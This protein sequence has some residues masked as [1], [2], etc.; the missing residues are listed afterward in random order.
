MKTFLRKSKIFAIVFVIANLFFSSAIFGQAIATNDIGFSTVSNSLDYSINALSICI[1]GK[2]TSYV[3]VGN[4]SSATELFQWQVSTSG[5]SGPFSI[6]S[7]NPGIFA[8]DWTISSNY[9]NT[10]GVY[11]FRRAITS[12]TIC[13]SISDSDVVRLEVNS[14]PAITLQPND[15]AITYATSTGF[16]VSA[17]GTA[18]FSYQW[19]ENSGAGFTDLTD[20]GIYS[21]TKA[22][23]LLFINPIVAM[24]GR[25]YRCVVTNSC[26]KVTSNVVALTVNKLDITGS[27][28]VSNKTYDGNNKAT[29]LS[30]SLNGVL[31]S[32]VKNVSL[33]GGTATFSDA[34]DAIGKT[35]TLI[36]STIKGN[37]VAN[38][39]LVSVST[40]T[41]DINKTPSASLATINRKPFSNKSLA[42]TSVE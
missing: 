40:T 15:Q 9:Y 34:N 22:S 25:T 14:A 20:V 26:G 37:A 16:S 10:P 18:P 28:T 27:F 8:K 17:S 6:V 32:D 11:Y 13:G 23:L 42:Q 35:V 12:C 5:P 7:P 21:G 24:S 2:P 39:N 31:S 30:R 4:P 3:I 19:Q 38:Y 33:S 36:G 29:V 41:A 1:D